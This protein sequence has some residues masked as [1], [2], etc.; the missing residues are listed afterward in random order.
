[1]KTA[2][3]LLFVL[4]AV[5]GCKPNPP[6]PPAQP[7]AQ[8]VASVS[9]ADDRTTQTLRDLGVTPE[10]MLQLVRN[11]LAATATPSATP[12]LQPPPT[13]IQE[14]LPAGTTP[15]PVAQP[16]PA[17]AA[18]APA[19]IAAT[20][21][22]PEPAP[23]PAAPAPAPA[24][25]ATT[26][27]PDYGPAPTVAASTVVVQP[28][29]EVQQ[30]QDFYAPLNNY[31]A[32]V[33]LPNYGRVWQPS[34]TMVDAEWRPYCH[35]GH[36]VYTDCGWYWQSDYSW[37]WAPF[38]YGRWCYLDH[39]RWVWLPDTVWAPAW[40]S[41]RRSETHCGWAPLPP[42][43]SFRVGVGFN[44]G[45]DDQFDLHFRLTATHYTF[46]TAEHFG[47]HNLVS[48]TIGANHQ[49]EIYRSTTHVDVSHSW[50]ATDHRVHNDG[51]GREWSE[52]VAHHP[53]QPV[54]I[55]TRPAAPFAPPARENP[56][57]AEPER[58][59][60]PEAPHP[61]EPMKTKFEQH[62]DEPRHTEAPTHVTSQPE[63][64]DHRNDAHE[65]NRSHSPDAPVV[66]VSRP[67]VPVAPIVPVSKPITYPDAPVITQP[68]TA[69]RHTMHDTRVEIPSALPTT[70]RRSETSSQTVIITPATETSD[71]PSRRA[72]D[73]NNDDSG[74]PRHR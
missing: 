73:D 27:T 3:Y 10:V 23:A 9:S 54:R 34:V 65:S 25:A 74:S 62:T 15:A 26:E 46:V 56:R 33:E 50:D 67:I 41:W 7:P 68:T 38:H 31:G 5:Q 57:F 12:A 19:P 64:P 36:W 1:M 14:A 40:V 45:H 6:P 49:A 2:L 8:P 51:P 16:A 4:I 24:V 52:R 66:P 21:W 63:Q 13:A 20:A 69:D 42:G 11:H 47:D 53:I 37:G 60:A 70:S 71:R 43:T 17:A 35:G 28:P 48:V 59:H 44:F 29:V 39:Y 30:V 18:P 55:V 61:V 72:N 22:Q 58:G 32:W